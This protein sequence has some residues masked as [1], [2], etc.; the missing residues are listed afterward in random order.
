VQDC[1]PDEIGGE[2]R[3]EGQLRKALVKSRDE[4]GKILV[5]R[6]YTNLRTQRVYTDEE[7]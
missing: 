5:L 6:K 7:S 3:W 2:I 4:R 1:C